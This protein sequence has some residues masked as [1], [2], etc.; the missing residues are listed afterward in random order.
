MLEGQKTYVPHKRNVSDSV[1]HNVVL[2]GN[3]LFVVISGV[4]IGIGYHL[5]S[6]HAAGFIKENLGLGLMI[7]GAAALIISLLG[8]LAA[9]IGSRCMVLLYALVMLVLI[10]CQVG[11]AAMVVTHGNDV[12]KLVQDK[13][14]DLS[15]PDQ[16]ALEQQFDCCGLNSFN[17]TR[18]AL[19]CP[20]G[21]DDGCV[22]KLKSDL[23]RE[24]LGVG[25]ATLAFAIIEV[26][27]VLCAC[28]LACRIKDAGEAEDA[29]NE[30]LQQAKEVNRQIGVQP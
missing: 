30:R 20:A 13:W 1:P 27:G 8:C 28:L 17:D 3:L 11:I 15:S 23:R 10:L 7:V 9:K 26:V 18:A 29:D 24:L 4:V 25:G 12:T 5:K 21:S 6:S 14:D 22:D 19:P 16:L 2:Y